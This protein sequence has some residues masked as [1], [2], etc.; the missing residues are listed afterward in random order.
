MQFFGEMILSGCEDVDIPKMYES[1]SKTLS[2]AVDAFS[3]MSMNLCKSTSITSLNFKR[4]FAAYSKM[5]LKSKRKDESKMQIKEFLENVIYETELLIIFGAIKIE[6]TV[7]D[8]Y[9]KAI[10]IPCGSLEVDDVTVQDNRLVI[11][12]VAV[13]KDDK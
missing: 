4:A 7:A 8:V 12:A 3:L 1:Y 13:K 9:E 10:V 5:L 6:C 11:N 2:C